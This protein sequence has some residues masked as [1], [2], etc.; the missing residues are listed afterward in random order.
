MILDEREY[1]DFKLNGKTVQLQTAIHT[2]D[3]RGNSQ[4]PRDSLSKTKYVE[5]LTSA[6]EQKHLKDDSVTAIVWKHSNGF[7]RGILVALKDKIATII[8]TILSKNETPR[9]VFRSR[10]DP[11]NLIVLEEESEK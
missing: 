5:V 10:I 6:D 8:T 4:I 7:Y 2:H 9:D 1:G 3:A 11:K